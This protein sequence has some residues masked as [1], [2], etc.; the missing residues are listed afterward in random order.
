MRIFIIPYDI[1]EISRNDLGGLND[2]TIQ[3]YILTYNDAEYLT[4]AD[5]LT[6][7]PTAKMKDVEMYPSFDAFEDQ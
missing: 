2:N 3:K 7:P 4:Q 6:Y 5:A 1:F